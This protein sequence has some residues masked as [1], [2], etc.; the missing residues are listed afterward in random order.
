MRESGKMR[1]MAACLVG[2]GSN[3]GDRAALLTRAVDLLR[4]HPQIERLAVSHW[5]ETAPVGGPAG[6]GDFLNG[7]VRF[8]TSLAPLALLALLHD[9]EASVGRLRGARWDARTIDLDLLLYGDEIRDTPELTL[10]HPRFA[11]RRFV[12]APAAEVAGELIHPLIGWSVARLLA[13]LDEAYPYIA[14]TG[15]AGTG[16]TELAQSVAQA[17]G[18]RWIADP[19][20]AASREASASA[21][22]HEALVV[23]ARQETIAVLTRDPPLP[24]ISDFW[25]GQSLAYAAVLATDAERAALERI[26]KTVFNGPLPPKLLVLL[27]AAP[28]GQFTQRAIATELR[29]LA[30]QP[31]RGPFLVFDAARPQLAR[32]ELLAAVAAMS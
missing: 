10:P 24:S 25:L 13:H 6:Q 17:K 12:L 27:D 16:K 11:V 21:L 14:I 8:D 9:V 7:A 5:R 18:L 1:D 15:A 26:E 20:R 4:V 22:E 23:S 19:V 30:T 3:L 28:P 29:R 32:D 2:L 31:G